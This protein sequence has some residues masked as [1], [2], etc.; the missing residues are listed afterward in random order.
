MLV[1]NGYMQQGPRLKVLVKRPVHRS[2][3]QVE[4]GWYL[5][6]SHRAVS[7]HAAQSVEVLHGLRRVATVE[8]VAS[9][10]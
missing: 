9:W 2:L 8:K 5:R 4:V 10:E 3:P 6:N 7:C 1:S